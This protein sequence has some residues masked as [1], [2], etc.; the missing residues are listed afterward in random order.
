MTGKAYRWSAP[1]VEKNTP[2][3]PHIKRHTPIKLGSFLVELL[4]LLL[5]SALLCIK[6]IQSA[7]LSWKGLVSLRMG[8]RTNLIGLE[9]LQIVG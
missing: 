7:S 9:L 8:E 4:L 1:G 2:E 5:H 6:N 3:D